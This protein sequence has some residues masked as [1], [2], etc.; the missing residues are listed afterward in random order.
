MPAKRS[1]LPTATAGLVHRHGRRGHAHGR[2]GHCHVPHRNLAADDDRPA[3]VPA[4]N[5]VGHRG[6][7]S[8]APCPRPNRVAVP[9][10]DAVDRSSEEAEQRNNAVVEQRSNA[11]RAGNSNTHRAMELDR[12]THDPRYTPVSGS[13]YLLQRGHRRLSIRSIAKGKAVVDTWRPPGPLKAHTSG[14]GRRRQWVIGIV[15]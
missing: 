15:G 8:Q 3:Q 11:V 7:S 2:H 13:S 4:P 1:H 5:P 14:A 10:A 6:H 12:S 9:G